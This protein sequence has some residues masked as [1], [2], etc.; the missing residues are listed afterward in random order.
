MRSGLDL[1]AQ[2]Y[3][4]YLQKLKD[5]EIQRQAIIGSE[6]IEGSLKFLE[7]QLADSAA[8]A[9]KVPGLLADVVGQSL[10]IYD[11]IVAL[12]GVFGELYAP[13]QAF[14]EKHPLAQAQFHMSFETKLA[15]TGYSSGFLSLVAQNRKGSFN[16]SVEGRERIDQLVRSA[17]FSSR[18]SIKSF[19]AGI[20]RA[21]HFDLRHESPPAAYPA[22]QLAR[23]CTI[24][25]LYGYI[26]G[27]SYI[28]PFFTLRWAGKDV[29][30]LSPGERGTLLLVFYLLIDR[31]DIPLIIDQPEENLDNQ[32]VFNVLV[33]SIKEARSRRQI[34]IVTHNPNLAVVC[35]ADQV[36]YASINKEGANSVSYESGAIENPAIN[37]RILD[38]LEGTRPAFDNRD[39]KYQPVG[40]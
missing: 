35:D 7:Q 36:I 31:A 17:D 30:Q 8:I 23:N 26:F 2:R 27:L 1:P 20:W 12:A 39:S 6:Q 14:I 22:D 37:R 38:V 34:I 15:D 11:G 19:L 25:Q 13:V 33:P 16:G 18:E 5:W 3:Q 28:S 29:Q 21:L 10:R 9:E 40:P 24:E 4:N 32:T